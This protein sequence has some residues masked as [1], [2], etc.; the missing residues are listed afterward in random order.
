MDDFSVVVVV[1]VVVVVLV[2]VEVTGGMGIV[3]AFV[4]AFVERFKPPVV[5]KNGT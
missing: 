2:E 5:P 4:V 1:V 3:V